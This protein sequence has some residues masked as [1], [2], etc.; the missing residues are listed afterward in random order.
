MLATL[1]KL[2]VVPSFSRPSV[3]NDNPY[4]EALFRTLKYTP[5]YPEG[6]FEEVAAAR[7]W[8]AIFV[9]W[10]NEQHL[11]SAICFVTPGQR[12]RGEEVALLQQRRA[13]YEAA[14]ARQPCRW[15]GAMRNWQPVG[16]VSLNPGKP[17]RKG[18]ANS[19]SVAT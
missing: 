2:G 4:S 8:V 11:P 19:K 14:K 9:P 5:A 1:Q 15:S 7:T 3:S 16:S 13:V 6:P 18:T 12:H 17:P 10:Y